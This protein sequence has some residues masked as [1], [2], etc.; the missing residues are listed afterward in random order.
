PF[1]LYVPHH[2]VHRPLQAKKELIAK[3]EK[4]LKPGLRHTNATYAAMIASVDESVGTVTAKL[5]ELGLTNRTVIVFTSDNGGLTLQQT[6]S[7][8]PLRVGKGTAY[9]GGVRVPWIVKWPGVAPPGSVCDEPVITPDLYPTFLEMAGAKHNGA[10][11]GMS[12]VPLL[13]DP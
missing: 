1:F 5:A 10:V 6:T 4:K 7:N 2:G 3:F 12:L 13:K 11:D 9:E 8:V